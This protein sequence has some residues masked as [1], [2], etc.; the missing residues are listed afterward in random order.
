MKRVVVIGAGVAGLCCAREL[1]RRG[2]HPIV[3]DRG[4]PGGGCSAGNAGWITPSLSGPLPAPGT[5]WSSLLGLLHRDSPA[6]HPPAR[7]AEPGVVAVA[8]PSQ[9]QPAR[10]SGR[11]ARHRQA[12]AALAATLRRAAR[13][14]RRARAARAPGSSSCSATSATPTRRGATSSTIAI[15]VTASRRACAA[16]RCA[17]RS[18]ASTPAWSRACWCARSATCVPRACAPA[19]PLRSPATAPSS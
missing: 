19:S 10:L 11:P 3:I 15:S 12:R 16:K 9:L 7:G 8:L 5:S 13:R 1:Q 4:P 14:R 17:P 6:L 2:V 18:R